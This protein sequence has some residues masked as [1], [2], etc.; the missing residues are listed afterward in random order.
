M[1]K[2][3]AR[4]TTN[5]ASIYDCIKMSQNNPDETTG[6]LFH[7]EY[8]KEMGFDLIR[9]YSKNQPDLTENISTD[10]T[11]QN[12]GRCSKRLA[13]GKKCG[14]RTRQ[15]CED[16]NEYRCRDCGEKNMS[17]VTISTTLI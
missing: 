4:R 10:R 16:C 1:Q 11:V 17:S 12:R 3:E 13:N 7:S 8:F 15:K 14:K 6:R 9:R 5:P 2:G